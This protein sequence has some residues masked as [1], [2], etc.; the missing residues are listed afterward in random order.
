MKIL[1]GYDGSESAKAALQLAI[2]YAGKLGAS[3][4]VLCYMAVWMEKHIKDIDAAKQE[5]ESVGKILEKA[6]IAHTTHLVTKGL[7]AGEMLVGFARNLAIDLIIIGIEKTSK[8]GKLVF[9]STA[10]AVILE[11]PCPVLTVNTND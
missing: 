6:E 3:V 4:E 9:G 11:A 7:S 1:L 2:E 8:V 10:Q 5:L